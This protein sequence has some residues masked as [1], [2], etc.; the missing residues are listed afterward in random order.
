MM[1]LIMIRAG[2]K[3]NV[4]RF[5]GDGA[6]FSRV[7]TLGLDINTQVLVVTSQAD[8]KGPLLVQVNGSKYAIDYN[9]AARIMVVPQD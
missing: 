1:P 3:A 9:L 7:R 5:E 4:L 8:V 6:E 2:E